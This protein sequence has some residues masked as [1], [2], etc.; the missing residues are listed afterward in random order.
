MNAEHRRQWISSQP[1]LAPALG[2]KEGSIR[3]INSYQS[4]KPEPF[5][6]EIPRDGANF[7]CASLVITKNQLLAAH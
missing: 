5:Q 2:T 6:S 3:I 4:V 7:F 1:P